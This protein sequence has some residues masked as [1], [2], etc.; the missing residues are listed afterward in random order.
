MAASEAALE[1]SAV[2]EIQTSL[3]ALRY[4][5]RSLCFANA[6]CRLAMGV[7]AGLDWAI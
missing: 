3:T 4:E 1:V 6:C 2:L 5:R 7:H